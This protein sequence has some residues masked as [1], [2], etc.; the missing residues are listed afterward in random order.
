M[1]ETEKWCIYKITSVVLQSE[2]GNGREYMQTLGALVVD[3][4][5]IVPAVSCLQSLEL[6]V[7]MKQGVVLL[8][9]HISS[10]SMTL[11]VSFPRSLE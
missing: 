3:S 11:L 2:V 5:S 4:S 7:S 8:S 1:S 6:K 10:S 9:A